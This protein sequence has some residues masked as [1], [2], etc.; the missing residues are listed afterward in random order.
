MT[1]TL[2]T[3]IPKSP[4]DPALQYRTRTG[5]HTVRFNLDG[6]QIAALFSLFVADFSSVCSEA[7][8]HQFQVPEAGLKSKASCQT[9]R[10]TPVDRKTLRKATPNVSTWN[11]SHLRTLAKRPYDQLTR[12][13]KGRKVED[14]FGG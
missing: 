6:E 3:C 4:Q 12:R 9:V 10:P 1:P 13:K 5:H 8:R 2:G 11:S 7:T 14:F